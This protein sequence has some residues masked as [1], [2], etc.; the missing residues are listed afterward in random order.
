TPHYENVPFEV[1]S[2][3]MWT[4]IEEI[5]SKI[6]SG[7]TPRG[8]N[9][10]AN[11]IPFFRSQNVYNDRLVYDDIK[12]ISEE[13]HQKM[14]GT[15]VLA[16]D[17]LL[18]ITGGSLGRCAVVPADFN[19]GNVSQHVCIMRSVLVEP[20][21]FHALVLSS[22]FAKSMK[23]TGSGREGLPKYNLEQMG[24]P[25][26]PLTEQQ[27]IVA[28]IEHWFA[29]IN[30]IE[31]GK[32]DLQTIIKQTKSK[33]L[34]IAIHGKLVPQDP[35]DE[36]AIEL[37]KC[38]NPHFTPCDNGHYT[39][40]PFE[41][42]QNWCWT[43]LGKIGKWQSGSTPN[44]LNKDYYNG[45]IP[46]LKTG[47]LN[48]GYITHIPEYITEKALNETS[49]KLN[50]TG[51]VLI[52]MYGATIGKIGILT[53]PTT[54]N[55]ACCACEVFN[56]IDKEFL[57]FFLLSHREEFIKMGGGGAQP[58]I[59]KEKIINTYIPLPPFA[60]QKRIVNAVNELFTKLDTIMESL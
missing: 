13:V 4:T 2:S 36:P 58:N 35:S 48:D 21:Y 50:P 51:S 55:Q 39:Q 27:R 52:A 45:N 38:I 31:Q 57:F 14:K 9:Y 42:P 16:N 6:G 59:S 34:D 60:E 44:R 41:A 54:T 49:V 1:P 10:S 29:L 23:I 56:G 43:T 47:D 11:G 15:E 40:L 25:L 24:F 46:W 3:W 53:F 26:P 33:I 32:A 37:L 22:Y 8:S 7:S 12:Y 19:C 28:E 5:C 17:L 18:N 30:Q 20:E